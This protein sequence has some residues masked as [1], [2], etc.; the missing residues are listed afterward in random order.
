MHNKTINNFN[1]VDLNFML[2][3]SYIKIQYIFFIKND[4]LSQTQYIFKQ[5][6]LTTKI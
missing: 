2:K 4:N 5:F 6:L 3:K 1:V